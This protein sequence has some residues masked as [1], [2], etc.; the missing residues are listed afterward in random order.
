MGRTENVLQSWNNPDVIV[1]L[2]EEVEFSMIR[3]VHLKFDNDW[4]LSFCH[5]ATK[6]LEFIFFI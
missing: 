5:E 6:V 2:F 4:L 3:E 1:L